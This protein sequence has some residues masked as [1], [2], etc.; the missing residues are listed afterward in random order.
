MPS[1]GD[2][3]ILA[4]VTWRYTDGSWVP[5]DGQHPEDPDVVA[6]N[7]FDPAAGLDELV[8]DRADAD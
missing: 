7:I 6:E 1:E 3:K 5:V 4:G 8:Q 2:I